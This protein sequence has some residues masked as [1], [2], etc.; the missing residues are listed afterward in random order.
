MKQ[1]NNLRAQLI[2]NEYND[3]DC[4]IVATD[5]I[6]RYMTDAPSIIERGTCKT[7]GCSIKNTRNTRNTTNTDKTVPVVGLNEIEFDASMENLEKSIVAN[8]PT[9][10]FCRKCFQPYDTFERIFGNHFFIN[11][12]QSLNFKI[13]SGAWRSNRRRFHV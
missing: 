12:I 6:R 13:Y 5:V 1:L 3:G 10:N 2:Y 4:S 9:E 8:F 11:V 7:K